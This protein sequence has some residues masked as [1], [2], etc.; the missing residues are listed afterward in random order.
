MWKTEVVVVCFGQEEG[1]SGC[2]CCLASPV[3]V[4]TDVFG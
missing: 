3:S 2:L 4:H 1:A